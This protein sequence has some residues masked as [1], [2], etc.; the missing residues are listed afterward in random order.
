MEK[1]MKKQNNYFGVVIEP[2]P[3]ITGQ[4]REPFLSPIRIETNDI[5][6]DCQVKLVRLGACFS[7]P[8]C[9]YGSC[10]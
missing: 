4:R 7:C 3:N 1:D 5:C 2:K 10:G 9:G 8:L 6:P